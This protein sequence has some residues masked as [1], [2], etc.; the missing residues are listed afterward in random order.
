MKT[1]PTDAA[2]YIEQMIAT[3]RNNQEPGFENRIKE[4]EEEKKRAEQ[5]DKIIHGGDLKGYK[6]KQMNLKSQNL[7]VKQATVHRAYQ[8]FDKNEEEL[9]EIQ[10]KRKNLKSS[11]NRIVED[12]VLTDLR[13]EI[14][15]IDQSDQNSDWISHFRSSFLEELE[16]VKSIDT[17][18]LFEK[19]ES[20]KEKNSNMEKFCVGRSYMQRRPSCSN[21][22]DDSSESEEYNSAAEDTNEESSPSVRDP[23]LSTSSIEVSK[24]KDDENKD[25][26]EDEE[27]CS[28]SSDPDPGSPS[29]APPPPPP[30]SGRSRRRPAGSASSPCRPAGP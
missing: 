5:M 25:P 28:L 15:R 1:A 8:G 22:I 4:L 10:E 16:S 18:I 29:P 6:L 30:P 24:D 21:Y 17:K 13:N 27:V 2:T 26:E 20:K 11:E 14:T 19:E 23:D 12:A 3:E 7:K 9:R